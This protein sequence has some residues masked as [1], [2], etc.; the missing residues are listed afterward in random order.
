MKQ[1]L[2]NFYNTVSKE[3]FESY[4]HSHSRNEIREY[5]NL[6]NTADVDRI[7]KKFNL[8]HSKE[9]SRAIKHAATVK[10]CMARYGTQNGG[11]TKEA[12][13]KI[14]QTNLERYGVEYTW[15]SENTKSKATKTKLERYNR[16]NVGQFG[17]AEHRAAMIDKYGVATPMESQSLKDKLANNMLAKYGVKRYAQCAEFHRKARKRYK[18][19][20]EK[21]DSSWEL[22]LWIYAIDHNEVIIRCPITLEYVANNKTHIYVPDFLYKGQLIEIKGDNWFDSNGELYCPIDHNKDSIFKAKYLCAI[23]N[24]IIFWRKTDV[25]FAIEYCKQ[26]YND[27]NWYKQFKYNRKEIK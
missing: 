20:E 17:T 2:I 22:A 18:Y 6:D 25:L 13:E 4:W 16:A 12:Q 23:A 11:W 24:N 9:E 26:K 14:K 19:M 10:T 27:K 5:F 8:R 21:F 3:I 7:A 15:Q 1:S